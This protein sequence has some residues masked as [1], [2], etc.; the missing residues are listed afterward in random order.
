M[1]K[2]KIQN[3]CNA[4]YKKD[5]RDL[6]LDIL[7]W[8]E[9]SPNLTA[10][11]QTQLQRYGLL[12]STLGHVDLIIKSCQLVNI[13]NLSPLTDCRFSIE[14]TSGR[15]SQL[16]IIV[17]EASYKGKIS[18]TVIFENAEDVLKEVSDGQ[19]KKNIQEQNLQLLEQL[20][21]G[22]KLNQ[23]IFGFRGG[24]EGNALRF[25]RI[26]PDEKTPT[27]RSRQGWAKVELPGGGWGIASA[28]VEVG[29]LV[30][31]VIVGQAQSN[32]GICCS[33]ILRED[34]EGIF[35]PVGLALDHLGFE[36]IN[37]QRPS[38]TLVAPMPPR[39]NKGDRQRNLQFAMDPETAFK[40]TSL[41]GLKTLGY[42]W[43]TVHTMMW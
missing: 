30:Y 29:D 34:S 35:L 43:R 27:I 5:V 2:P 40:M 32:T 22:L 41:A 17:T 15:V 42:G 26:H 23:L 16:P 28:G 10:R 18:S 39:A 8:F 6:L 25:L 36:S 9:A 11:H 1:Q 13:D 38:Q 4:D 37:R 19:E 33:L 24:C 12:Q 3:V 31:T 14:F 7:E 20:Q 21:C